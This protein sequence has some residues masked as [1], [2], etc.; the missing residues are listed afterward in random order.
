LIKGCLRIETSPS[1]L[2]QQ[3]VKV[4]KGSDFASELEAALGGSAKRALAG[5][6][7]Q[8]EIEEDEVGEPEPEP[9]IWK[10]AKLGTPPVLSK[11]APMDNA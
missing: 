8:R 4:E 11:A 6:R 3:V 10:T 9:I 7:A 2:G 5:V 1:N